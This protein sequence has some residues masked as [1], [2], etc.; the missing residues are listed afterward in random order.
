MAPLEF[1][2]PSHTCYVEIWPTYQRLFRKTP[3]LVEVC[4]DHG[5]T[6]RLFRLLRE[7][8]QALLM[9]VTSDEE[10]QEYAI[11]N[12]L[13]IGILVSRRSQ[14]L[15]HELLKIFKPALLPPINAYVPFSLRRWSGVS[16]WSDTTIHGPFIS[17]SHLG[18]KQS[19]M[20]GQRFNFGWH[21]LICNGGSLFLATFLPMCVFL[22]L[23]SLPRTTML[24]GLRHLN[25]KTDIERQ[26]AI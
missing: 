9:A 16:A 26:P 23:H 3:S 11:S 12:F 18:S 20:N 2:L 15:P 5:V 22:V 14:M 25:K 19:V 8:P 24:S 17:S 7:Q 13:L 1:L 6:A 4:N 21:D 10:S